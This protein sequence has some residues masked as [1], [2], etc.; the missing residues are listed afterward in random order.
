MQE[1]IDRHNTIMKA[2]EVRLGQMQ[3]IITEKDEQ[4]KEYQS[5]LNDAKMELGRIKRF[6][7]GGF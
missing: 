2:F 5:L 6:E 3:K 1:T 4:I 7:A